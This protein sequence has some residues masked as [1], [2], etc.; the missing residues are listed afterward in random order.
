MEKKE[1]VIKGS[2]LCN[3]LRVLNF[4]YEKG[5]RP[6]REAPDIRNFDKKIWIFKVTDGLIDALN[7]YADINNTGVFYSREGEN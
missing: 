1:Y 3:R 4:L 5:F 7:E 6:D 2:F